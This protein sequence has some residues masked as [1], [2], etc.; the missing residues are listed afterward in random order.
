MPAGDDVREQGS[1]HVV[2]PE[3]ELDIATMPPLRQQWLAAAET[4][5]PVRFVIDLEAVTFLDSTALGSIVSL[6]N[7]QRGHGGEV[8]IVDSGP[9]IVRTFSL[10][11]LHR[12]FEI[13]GQPPG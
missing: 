3:G 12:V 11:G 7:L 5:R 4:H 8:A 10:T 1:E 2:R 6:Y 13:N 9:T